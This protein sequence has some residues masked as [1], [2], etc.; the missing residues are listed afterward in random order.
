MDARA[1]DLFAGCGGIRLAFDQAGFE[2]VGS[3]EIDRFARETYRANF[4]SAPAADVREIDPS[5][6][7]GF[8][9]LCAGFPCQ[10]FSIAGQSKNRSLGR[11]TGFDD[12]RG[13]LF[14]EVARILEARRPRAFLLENVKHLVLRERG[15]TFARIT[16]VLENLGYR[17]T[18][19]IINS[20]PWV[21]QARERVYIVGFRDGQPFSFPSGP[22]ATGPRLGSILEASVDGKYTLSDRTWQFLQAYRDKHRA[23]GNGFGYSLVTGQSV[24]R[25]LS[26]R[27]GK[28]GSEILL[29]QPG[30]N[31]RR[32]TPRECARLMG[33]P[34]SFQIPVSDTQAYKQFGNSVVVPVVR[35]IAGRM[36]DTLKKK[37][38]AA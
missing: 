11:S 35:A 15:R 20:S 33:F 32:L 36:S 5:R 10:A 1:L 31:P 3:W 28:D 4:A 18:W 13:T 6:L 21:P 27:Y 14:F 12:A 19:A 29:E 23:A 16:A 37:E 30:R 7:P 2:N 8:D 17:V 34:D 38:Q 26:A 22:E 9:V 24:T 25:T